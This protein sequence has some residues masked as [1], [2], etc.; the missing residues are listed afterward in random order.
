ME[1]PHDSV[2]DLVTNVP[3]TGTLEWIGIARERRGPILRAPVHDEPPCP[4][5]GKQTETSWT[6]CS[7][8]GAALGSGSGTLIDSAEV[9]PADGRARAS[10]P[11]SVPSASSLRP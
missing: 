3:L 5:C 2:R 8:C 1:T 10:Y 11:G 9:Y 6:F 4:S 7:H